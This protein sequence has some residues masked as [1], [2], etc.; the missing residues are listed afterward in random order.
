MAP[1]LIYP[2]DHGDFQAIIAS[3]KFT[4]VD[5]FATWCGPC[6]AVEP[7]FAALPK[8]YPGSQF[9]KVDVDEQQEIAASCGV[10]AMPT[11]VG[12]VKGQKVGE[13]VGADW[14]AVEALIAKHAKSGDAWSAAG[15]GHKL[16]GDDAQP[17]TGSTSG[18][19][20]L[21]SGLASYIW[22]G[23]AP[24]GPADED[25]EVQKAIALSLQE[26]SAD[27][28][29]KKPPS[30]KTSELQIR[31]PSGSTVRHAFDQNDTI[32]DVRVWLASAN[33]ELAGRRFALATTFPKKEYGESSL[34]NTLEEEK[35]VGRVQLVVVMKS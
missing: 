5:F 18:G 14:S 28:P 32:N 20:G 17:A 7:N 33:K 34:H 9:V 8:K 24:Q 6:K 30:G 11:F 1:G 22:S 31:L 10:R 12:F 15:S 19:G 4:L 26:Q 2:K 13:V 23:S 35:L 27:A 3:P 25:D 29:P 16:G 21:L